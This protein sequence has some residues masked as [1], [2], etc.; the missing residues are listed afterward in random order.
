MWTKKQIVPEVVSSLDSDLLSRIR[1]LAWDDGAPKRTMPNVDRLAFAAG[2]YGGLFVW[3][4][5]LS[6]L[7]WLCV[8]VF[9]CGGFA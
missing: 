6:W 5:W 4:S 1:N 7:S 9:V 3:L 2:E 8:V